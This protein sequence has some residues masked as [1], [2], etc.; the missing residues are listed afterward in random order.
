MTNFE[1]VKKERHTKIIS[2][3]REFTNEKM[4]FMSNLI[5]YQNNRV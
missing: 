5:K 2:K 3:H 4:D 1:R